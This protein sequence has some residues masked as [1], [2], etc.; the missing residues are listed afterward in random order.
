MM[1]QIISL[2]HNN[3]N[4]YLSEKAATILNVYASNKMASKYINPK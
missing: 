2:P 4:S 3:K 1:I